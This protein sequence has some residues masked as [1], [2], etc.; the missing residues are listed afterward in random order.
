MARNNDDN[1]LKLLNKE[2][3]K[4]KIKLKFR[5]YDVCPINENKLEA[6]EIILKYADQFESYYNKIFILTSLCDRCFKDSV[7][8]LVKI[9][10]YFLNKVYSVP[11]DETYLLFLCDTIAK[12][13]A[14]EYLDLYKG[15]ISGPITQS[16]ES[17][18]KMVSKYYFD[19]FDDILLTLIK[20]ENLIPKAWIGEVSEDTKYWCSYI[21]MKCIV[22]KKDKKY[23]PFF[24]EILEDEFMSWI[25]FS[26]SKYKNKLT[27]EWKK[28]YKLL[29]EKGIKKIK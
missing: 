21:A 8:Y 20:K 7:P 22:N 29:A 6:M 15:I 26:D 1:L 3:R 11:I 24:H 14:F 10:H 12:I 27:L 18:I 4:Y 16:A 9:Y 19:E 28:K 25:N 5:Y 23:L 2:L 17:I 13:K